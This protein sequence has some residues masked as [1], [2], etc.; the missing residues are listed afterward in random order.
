MGLKKGVYYEYIKKNTEDSVYWL[1]VAMRQAQSD[2]KSLKSEVEILKEINKQ[3][4]SEYAPE[5]LDTV[6]ITIK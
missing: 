5:N 3:L 2:I 6:K 4:K 1:K